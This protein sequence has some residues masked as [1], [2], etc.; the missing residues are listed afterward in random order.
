MNNHI[1]DPYRVIQIHR[2]M[3]TLAYRQT[4]VDHI[5]PNNLANPK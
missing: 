5:C 4:Q 1:E 2:L 3:Q